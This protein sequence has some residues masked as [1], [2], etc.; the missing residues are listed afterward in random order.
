MQQYASAR[1]VMY[2]YET[3]CAPCRIC[4]SPPA[5]QQA[6]SKPRV[7]RLVFL[8]KWSMSLH[9]SGMVGTLHLSPVLQHVPPDAQLRPCGA[10]CRYNVTGKHSSSS[11]R[12][13]QGADSR[14][15]QAYQSYMVHVKALRP[16]SCLYIHH[17]VDC[18]LPVPAIWVNWPVHLHLTKLT[19]QYLDSTADLADPP[20]NCPCLGQ[21]SLLMSCSYLCPGSSLA[22]PLHP[23]ICLCLQGPQSCCMLGHELLC[24]LR[25]RMLNSCEKQCLIR[26]SYKLVFHP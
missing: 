10:L 17:W 21:A 5:A 1:C 20:Q 13:S 4:Y 15:E 9:K 14:V 7:T 19:I 23:C 22:L 18:T 8:R 6:A 16:P 2:E 11:V 26:L 24:L 3:P 25:I 12:R